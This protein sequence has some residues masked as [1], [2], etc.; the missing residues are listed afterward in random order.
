MEQTEAILE[1]ETQAQ[2]ETSAGR[3]PAELERE[4]TALR[5]Q[6]RRRALADE[7][8]ALLEERGIEAR[9]VPF[10]LGE[11]SA[12]TRKKVEQFDRQL[13]EALQRHLAAHL[14]PGEPRD[15]S[16]GRQSVRR[17]GIRRV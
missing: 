7:A 12:A 16:A 6:A 1:R 2:A 11:D 17:R 13:S 5:E 4:L 14:P 15:F 3:D 8:K 10:V 9:F